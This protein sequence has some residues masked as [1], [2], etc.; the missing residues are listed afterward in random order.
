MA[1]KAGSKRSDFVQTIQ[2]NGWKPVIHAP[3]DQGLVCTLI[4]ETLTGSATIGAGLGH[5]RPGEYHLKHHHPDGEEFYVF[6]K[7]AA[8]VHIDGEDVIAGP[9]TAVFIPTGVVHS[10]RNEGHEPVELV[11]GISRPEYSQIGF[12]FDE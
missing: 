5:L 6:T 9:G 8:T 12:E 10:I 3:R 4:S 1:G 11:W 2:G 7:G